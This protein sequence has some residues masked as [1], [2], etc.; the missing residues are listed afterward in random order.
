MP[1]R[2]TVTFDGFGKAMA[3]L[4]KVQ[5][6]IDDH[7]GEDAT[8]AGFNAAGTVF[9]K[10]FIAE[11]TG[12]GLGGW[13]DLEESTVRKR[14]AAGF[15]G[16]HPILFRYGDLRVI[17]ATSLRIADGSGTFSATDPTGKT[18]MVQL[19]MGQ[20]GGYARASGDKAWNQVQTRNAPAR[21]F[22][23]TTRTVE[24]AVRKRVVETLADN[25]GRL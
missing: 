3:H 18:I 6:Y 2:M 11:G 4:K 1:I 10:N 22:W 14:E 20:D 7:A 9:E 21:P 23:F 17:T 8:R 25:I 13:A 12:F 24:I 5:D 16:E 15:S 19:H